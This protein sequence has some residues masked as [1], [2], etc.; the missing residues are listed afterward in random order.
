VWLQLRELCDTSPVC[1]VARVQQLKERVAELEARV[2]ELEQQ[3]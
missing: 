3:Q 2:A 1:A